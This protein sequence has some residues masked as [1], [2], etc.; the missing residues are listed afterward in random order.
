LTYDIDLAE[1]YL[2]VPDK[3]DRT[4]AD[5]LDRV[6][7][8]KQQAQDEQAREQWDDAEQALLGAL[9]AVRRRNT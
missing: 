1:D 8:R 6:R 9:G 5:A 4:L 3:V 2:V 7:R